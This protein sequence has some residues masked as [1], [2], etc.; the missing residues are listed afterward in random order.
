M[1]IKAKYV[2]NKYIDI[3]VEGVTPSDTHWGG[4][5]AMLEGAKFKLEGFAYRRTFDNPTEFSK[6]LR[7]T[8]SLTTKFGGTEPEEIVDPL[9][10]LMDMIAEFESRF[11]EMNQ[12]VSVLKK[13]DISAQERL[14][15]LKQQLEQQPDKKPPA[16]RKKK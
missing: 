15:S 9:Q 4:V 14:N 10:N 5:K 1:E 8:R 12:E 3:F 6:W 11:D 2:T 16:R 7:H 13:F